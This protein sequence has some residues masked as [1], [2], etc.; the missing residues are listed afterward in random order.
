MAV[1]LQ[2]RGDTAAA[3]TA[4][5]PIL[6]EREFAIEM[7]TKKMK[8]GDGTTAWNSL[9]YLNSF[10]KTIQFA[11]TDEYSN[12]AAGSNKFSFRVPFAMNLTEIRASL[13]SQQT[14]GAIFTV[15]VKKSGA[16]MLFPKLTID[17]G[18]KTSKTAASPVGIVSG[19]IIDDE[20]VSVDVLQIG[21]GTAVGLKIT[22]I[23]V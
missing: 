23:G 16:S 17:N 19:N 7:D 6:A 9:S 12:I 20:E 4:A 5:N 21:S 1:K 3:W 10:A 15:D 18:E 2:L 22:M 14:S 13:V 11:V 8:V